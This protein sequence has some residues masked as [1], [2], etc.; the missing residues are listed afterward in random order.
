MRGLDGFNGS[1]AGCSGNELR[2]IV[3][4][5][6]SGGSLP[7]AV[8]GI[9]RIDLSTQDGNTLVE[10]ER[11][12]CGRAATMASLRLASFACIAS[13]RLLAVSSHTI[14]LTKSGPPPR[15]S[16]YSAGPPPSVVV[17]NQERARRVGADVASPVVCALI[18]WPAST[19]SRFLGQPKRSSV[20][21]PGR[22]LFSSLIFAYFSLLFFLFLPAA[23]ATGSGDCGTSPSPGCPRPAS[24]IPRGCSFCGIAYHQSGSSVVPAS[25]SGLVQGPDKVHFPSV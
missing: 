5:L 15:H 12:R 13:T 1:M 19:K 2:H 22:D 6:V 21:R 18:T 16:A 9:I 20:S 24:E 4:T 25:I 10:V 23:P 3:I 11:V 8:S 17:S 14:P 7:R